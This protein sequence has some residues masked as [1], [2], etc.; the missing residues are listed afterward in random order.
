MLV[1]PKGGSVWW[2]ASEMQLHSKIE[3]SEN[4]AENVKEAFC[5]Q[6]FLN[7][8]PETLDDITRVSA[9]RERGSDHP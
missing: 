4:A 3:D 5:S 9:K 6:A 8:S 2:E 1:D 7:I